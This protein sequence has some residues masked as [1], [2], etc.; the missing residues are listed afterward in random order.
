MHKSA[1]LVYDLLLRQYDGAFTA[2]L[3]IFLAIYILVAFIASG[4]RDKMFCIVLITG[5]VLL[6]TAP[7]LYRLT[8]WM[9]MVRA[10]GY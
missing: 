1:P 3:L 5:T 6:I 2:V 9:Y 10:F 4:R 8:V 7:L